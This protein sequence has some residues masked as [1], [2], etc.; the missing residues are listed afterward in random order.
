MML[1][2]GGQPQVY[3][4]LDKHWIAKYPGQLKRSFWITTTAPPKIQTIASSASS[5]KIRIYDWTCDD[6]IA[7][8]GLFSTDPKQLVNNILFGPNAAI[9]KTEK[10]IKKEALRRPSP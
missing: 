4:H 2:S 8:G 3:F 10:V 7:D 1:M 9:V 6:V 5:D